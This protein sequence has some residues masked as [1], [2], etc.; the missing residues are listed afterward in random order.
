MNHNTAEFKKRAVRKDEQGINQRQGA[1]KWEVCAKQIKTQLLVSGR[2]REC[3]DCLI[4]SMKQCSLKK[5]LM[6]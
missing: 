4:R 1:K 3:F 6:H 2:S 5:E